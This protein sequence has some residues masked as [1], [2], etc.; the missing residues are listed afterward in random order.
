M[1][2]LP[3]TPEVERDLYA[4]YQAGDA[5]AGEQLLLRHGGLWVTIADRYARVSSQPEKSIGEYRAMA[6]VWAAETLLT[7]DPEKGKFSSHAATTIRGRFLSMFRKAQKEMS[8]KE[9][10]YFHVQLFWGTRE[11]IQPDTI[12]EAKDTYDQLCR[13]VQELPPKQREVIQRRWLRG[14]EP[15]LNEVSNDIG[16]SIAALSLRERAAIKTLRARFTQLEETC[17]TS[18]K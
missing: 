5:K 12:A 18:Q 7:F 3:P 13:L 14:S 9:S 6:W 15:S 1:V 10:V 17:L 16:V 2:D 11:P 4:K 8:R